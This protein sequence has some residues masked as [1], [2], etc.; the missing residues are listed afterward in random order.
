[1]DFCDPNSSML[2]AEL[3]YDSKIKFVTFL[4]YYNFVLGCTYMQRFKNAIQL[5]SNIPHEI[6]TL[7]YRYDLETKLALVMNTKVV[8]SDSL[9]ML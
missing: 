8:T 7:H 4:K 9:N 6:G 5:W 2:R 3:A 1:M